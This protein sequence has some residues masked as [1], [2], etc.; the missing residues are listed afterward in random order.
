M[1][2]RLS[3]RALRRV[4][5]DWSCG[6][7]WQHEGQIIAQRRDGL[8]GQVASPLDNPFVPLGENGADEVR[9]GVL[10]AEDADDFGATLDVAV[11]AL[12]RVVNRYEDLGAEVRRR[13]CGLRRTDEMVIEPTESCMAVSRVLSPFVERVVIA[14]PLQVKAIDNAHVKTDKVDAGTLV[15][16]YTAGYHRSLP[17]PVWLPVSWRSLPCSQGR[18]LKPSRDAPRRHCPRRAP[19]PTRASTAR[20]RGMLTERGKTMEQTN[21]VC[22]Q[23]DPGHSAMRRGHGRR[24]RRPWPNATITLD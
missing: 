5:P 9:D 12:Q 18:K 6:R 20:E 11:E 22:C 17:K 4:W 21:G 8:Q 19:V 2:E 7:G 10:F 13:L 1:E 15:S 23:V 14:N 3:R 16:L 24:C